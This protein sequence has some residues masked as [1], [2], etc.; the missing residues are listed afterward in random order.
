MPYVGEIVEIDQLM[1]EVQEV[2]RRRIS[3]V[4]VRRRPDATEEVQRPPRRSLSE[5]G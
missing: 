5:G 4:R 1:F 3:K 2:E